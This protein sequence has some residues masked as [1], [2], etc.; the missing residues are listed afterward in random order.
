MDA[1]ILATTD[2]HDSLATARLFDFQ[3]NGFA[4]VDFQRDDITL[5]DFQRAAAALRRHGTTRIF[6]TLITDD[7]G[8]LCGRFERMEAFRTSDAGLAALI[9]GLYGRT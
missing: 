4:G 9:A 1:A 8:R 2:C 3:V 7:V 6:P 5:A